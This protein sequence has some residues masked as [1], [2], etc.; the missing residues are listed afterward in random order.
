MLVRVEESGNNLVA[1]SMTVTR[2]VATSG[3]STYPGGTSYP[4]N[5]SVVRGTI[6]Y[7]DTNRRTIEV[8]RG[9]GALVTVDYETNTPVY[10]KN[11]T[12]R[13]PT[14]SAATSG[15]PRAQHRQQP[16]ARR[17]VSVV[18]SV[19]SN[20]NGTYGGSTGSST[21]SQTA[22]L[23]GTVRPVDTSRRTIELESASGAR[24]STAATVGT[25]AASSSRTTRTRWSRCRPAQPGDG[26]RARR[27]SGRA[28]AERHATTPFAQRIFLVQ[29]VR[30]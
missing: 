13:A 5:D 17:A 10:F 15:H 11:Q 26:H 1:E 3:G 4:T 7:V 2:N 19:N 22:T 25:T 14:S 12:Y 28:G 9:N 30:R 16:L 20:S 21:S 24:T 23:R 18:R 27:R 29:D 6:R 8:D